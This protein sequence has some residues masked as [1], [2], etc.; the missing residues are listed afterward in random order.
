M[1]KTVSWYVYDTLY[2]QPEHDTPPSPICNRDVDEATINI[3]IDNNCATNATNS[4]AKLA[5][6]FGTKLG[7]RKA[8][9]RPSKSAKS[10]Q[11]GSSPDVMLVDDT[12]DERK[13]PTKRPKVENLASIFAKP[14]SK[15]HGDSQSETGLSASAPLA[16]KLRPRTLQDFVGQ[17]HLTGENSLLLSLIESRAMGSM[18]L[19][20]PPGC[21]KTTLARLLAT[22]V[23]ATFK[24]LSATSSGIGDVK[25]IFEEAKR[26][27]KL[28]GRRT[29]LFM[30]EIQRFN[31]AQQDIFLPYVENG[32]IILIGA[33][34]ENPSFKL[35]SALLS[36]CRV[37]VLE[38]LSDVEIETI[39]SKAIERVAP[40]E[41]TPESKQE[42]PSS[43][44]L[45]E[46]SED[47]SKPPENSRVINSAAP[48]LRQVSPQ[49][50][51]TIIN[52]SLGDART[53]LSLLEMVLTAPAKASDAGLIAHLRRSVSSRYDRSGE[54]RYDMISALHKS[55]RGSEGSAALYWLARMLTAGEDPLYIAR[56]LIVVASED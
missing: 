17:D 21:G 19:W 41:V 56:R 18:I 31:K 40:R 48:L 8:D 11:R 32:W 15:P 28:T 45:T 10:S 14:F 53:A 3:H 42:A 13:P 34:T 52:L 22:T 55:I 44:T 25:T 6:I 39:L 24:E 5:P 16:E 20:G 38:R 26:T 7:K 29:I 51:K 54:D 46:T 37:F 30:D 12:E 49:I 2:L 35:N 36:R 43:Q 23:D 27:L 47:M 4:S 50:M 1:V 33:T 9:T